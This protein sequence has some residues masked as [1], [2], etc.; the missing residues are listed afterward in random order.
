MSDYKMT[1]Y[2]IQSYFKSL[3]NSFYIAYDQVK[4]LEKEKKELNDNYDETDLETVKSL[5]EM[6]SRVTIPNKYVTLKYS[7][8]ELLKEKALLEAKAQEYE[9]KYKELDDTCSFWSDNMWQDYEAVKSTLY[10]IERNNFSIIVTTKE[11]IYAL[12]RFYYEHT[13]EDYAVVNIEKEYRE[14][15]PTG[16]ELYDDFMLAY[17]EALDENGLPDTMSTLYEEYF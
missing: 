13:V 12:M 4:R 6:E 15:F 16:E 8:S 7:R 10:T 14:A 5:I 2:E 11:E 3:C 1:G 17:Q 9:R